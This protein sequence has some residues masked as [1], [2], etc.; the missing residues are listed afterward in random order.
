MSNN[1]EQ[2][3]VL[4]LLEA[5]GSPEYYGPIWRSMTKEYCVIL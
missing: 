5:M 2:D 3:Y 1:T 4:A